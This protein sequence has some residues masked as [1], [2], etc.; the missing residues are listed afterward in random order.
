MGS[1]VSVFGKEKLNSS[2]A[3]MANRELG[4][5]GLVPAALIGIASPLCMYGTLPISAAFARKGI[6]DEWLAA[7]MVG[8]ILLN[9]QLLF[10]TGAIGR[11]AVAV[12]FVSGFLAAIAAGLLVHFLYK[13]KPF[14]NFENFSDA[15][16]RDTDPNI[17]LRFIKNLWRNLKAT[18][19]AF[20]IGVSLA[21]LFETFVPAADVAGLL[22][23]HQLFGYMIAM[24]IGVPLFFC[25]GATIPLLTMWLASGLSWGTAAIFMISG[26]AFKIVSLGAL[27]VVLG[28]KHFLFYILFF[29]VFSLFSGFIVDLIFR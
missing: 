23:S 16:N 8:S 18:G 3:S 4:L 17:V 13:N 1:L 14:F 21:S 2:F 22:G 9:P 20:L 5:F 28:F 29:I 25:G 26:Q 15:Q 10:Y 7:F 27:K 19:P 12:R 6:R 11:I 24:S